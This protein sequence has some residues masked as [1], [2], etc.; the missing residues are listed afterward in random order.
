MPHD[1][2]N[3]EPVLE[4]LRSL[5]QAEELADPGLRSKIAPV[6]ELLESMLGPTTRPADAARLIGVSQ[7]ALY[8]WIDRGDISTV[9]T[10]DGR[11]EIP[12]SELLDLVDHVDEKRNEGF[13]RPLAAAIHERLE[14]ATSEV[15][16]NRLL[17]KRRDR[18]H[19]TAELQS[20]AYHRLVAERLDERLLEDA[21]RKLERWRSTNRIHPY[22]ADQ[23]EVLLEGSLVDVARAIS[24]D[25]PRARELRQTSPFAGVLNTQE[26][27]LLTRAVEERT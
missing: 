13:E 6:V 9:L 24:A 3:V 5:R 16:L 15:D 1:V 21:R 8:R 17:P 4:A 12:V 18:G 14:R 27:R 22:W 10:P 20:L 11:R 25:T 19:R 7:P 2:R 26:R 23:W